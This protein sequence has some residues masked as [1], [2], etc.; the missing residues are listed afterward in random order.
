MKLNLG[1]GF[2]KLDGYINIDSSD[3][4]SPDKIMDI[5]RTPW[6]FIDNEVTGVL[7]ASVMEH[8]PNEPE[9]FFAILK[10]LYRV[11]ADG[12]EIEV[13]CPFPTHRWQVVDFTHTKAIHPEGLEMLNKEFCEQLVAKQSTK[14][15]LAL[16]YGIDFRLVKYQCTIDKDAPGSIE[17]VLG[18]YDP[19]LNAHYASL[20]NNVGAVQRFVL[21]VHK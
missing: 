16:I 12:S 1:C 4:C 3:H 8:L 21:R 6:P 9:A 13:E 2:R 17:K 15:P 20:F 19:S 11:C 10:E 18:R 7:M 5:F 14:T